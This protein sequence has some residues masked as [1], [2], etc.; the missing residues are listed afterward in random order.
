[1]HNIKKEENKEWQ[2]KKNFFKKGYEFY[3]FLILYRIKRKT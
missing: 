3:Y 2:V 1:M